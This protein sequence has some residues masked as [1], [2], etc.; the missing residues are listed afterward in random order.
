MIGSSEI[1]KRFGIKNRH[2]QWLDERGYVKPMHAGHKRHYTDEQLRLVLLIHRL[3]KKRIPL[4]RIVP[5]L[6][7]L[8]QIVATVPDGHEIF[9]SGK[10]GLFQKCIYWQNVRD[11][12][13]LAPKDKAELLSIAANHKGWFF[14]VNI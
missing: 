1:T 10:N 12:R 2:L 14:V 13:V 9:F 7:K 4:Q 3:R 5:L 6:P 8:R 11:I